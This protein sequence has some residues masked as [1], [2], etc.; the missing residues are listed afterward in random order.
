MSRAEEDEPAGAE[1]GPAGAARR[2][3]TWVILAVVAAAL[4][5][6]CC[7]VVIGL[8]VSWSAGLLGGR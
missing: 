4:L 2:G 3:P 8:A 7:S 1:A 5:V 6:C